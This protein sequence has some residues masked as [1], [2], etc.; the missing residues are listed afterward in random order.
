MFFLNLRIQVNEASLVDANH[1]DAVEVLRNAGNDIK[2]VVLREIKQDNA[3]D[4]EEE[5]ASPPDVQDMG[6]GVS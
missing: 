1:L 3:E 5:V 4:G 6:E 2:I